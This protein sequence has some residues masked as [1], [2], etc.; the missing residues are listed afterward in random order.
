[1]TCVGLSIRMRCR[2]QDE[3]CVVRVSFTASHLV[4][5]MLVAIDYSAATA[6]LVTPRGSAE[7]RLLVIHIFF[8][9]IGSHH[10]YSRLYFSCRASCQRHR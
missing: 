8:S 10:G 7:L 1:M 3:V 5:N 4:V 9:A 2:G 6:A